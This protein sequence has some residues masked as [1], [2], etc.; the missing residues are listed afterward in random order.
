MS[1]LF[2]NK[3]DQ[4]IL[5]DRFNELIDYVK[6]NFS[7]YKNIYENVTPSTLNTLNDLCHFPII[8]KKFP[9]ISVL[10]DEVLAKKPQAYFETS[11]TSGNPFPVIPD[12]G[13]ER[14]TE[15]ANFIYERLSLDKTEIKS[16]LIAL[17]FEMNPIGLKYFL[18]L[19]KLGIMAIPAGVKTHLCSPKKVLE[20]FSRLKPELLIARPLETLRYAEAMMAQGINPA[21]S[22]I[23]K[24]ILTG[25][26]ISE[27]KFARISHLYGGASVHGVYGLTELDSGG[28]VSCSHYQYHLPS[29]PY[30][31][32]ELL[33][34]DFITPIKNSLEIGNIILTN[35][36]KNHMPLLRYKTG[37]LGKL[38]LDCDCEYSTPVINVIGRTSDII[39]CQ[40]TGKIS[41]PIEIENILFQY[42]KI[43]CDYQIIVKNKTIELR[44]ELLTGL[45]SMQIKT[46]I[47]ELK[48]DI[49]EQL[50][51]VIGHIHVFMP[52]EL[53]NKLGIAKNKAGTLYVLENASEIETTKCLQLNYCCEEGL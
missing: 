42:E 8:D 49:F 27:A 44:I 26:I 22:S 28:L 31:I 43:S 2:L 34:D 45:D 39:K 19:N 15:F 32:V 17:P 47:Q 52:G 30:L 29:K 41:F 25:E 1:R 6:E 33:R 14:S 16:A 50:S 9:G 35:T 11:G 5:C 53:T 13:P 48:A 10:I 24:I 3:N 46:L 18:A 37:D 40:V 38:K 51:L 23:K 4:K 12:L 21:T 7:F 20:I 36:H